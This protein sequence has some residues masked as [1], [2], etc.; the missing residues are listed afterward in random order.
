MSDVIDTKSALKKAYDEL[1]R[2]RAEI[3][4]LKRQA[5]EA[6]AIVGMACRFPGGADTPDAFWKLLDDEVDAITEIP[7]DR[8]DADAFYNADPATVGKMATRYGGFLNDGDLF[9]YEFFDISPKVA[10]LMDPQQRLLLEVAWEALENANIAVDQIQGAPAGVF[11]G[12]TCFDQ[13]LVL[14]KSVTNS[15]SHAGTSTALNMAAGRLS[16]ALGVCGPSMAIDTACSSSL[17]AIHLACQSLRQRESDLALAGGVNYILSPE[18][19]VSFSQARMLAPD[20]RCKTFDDSADGYSRGEGCGVV[21]L[22]RLSDALASGDEILGVIRGSAVNQD[23]ASGGL[24][25]PNGAAQ[26]AVI[27]KALEQAAVTPDAVAYVEAHGTGTPL[28]DPIEIESLAKVYGVGRM[29]GNPILV[30]SVK[31][32]IGHLE[33]ASG[34]AGLIKVLLSFKNQKIPRHLHFNRPN[35]HIAWNEIPVAVV[36]EAIAWPN[37]EQRRIAG[38]SSFGFSGTNAHLI[39]EEPPARIPSSP[40]RGPHVLTLSAKTEES[41]LELADRY[42]RLFDERPELDIA[43]VCQSSN[44]GRSNFNRRLALVTSSIDD[45]RRQLNEF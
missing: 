17:V 29:P 31:T 26:E 13:A 1:A 10:Q 35:L 36:N 6:I 16:Y 5:T 44:T 2:R 18:V 22:K 23:G 39:V 19:M 24:T 20:G 33:P 7:R 43:A 3:E 11:V 15:N 37:S 28:G 25:V 38:I 34:I 41:L 45:A 12:I 27:R 14:G 42:R 40:A 32:N 8:W 4:A 9:D 30:A 21:V